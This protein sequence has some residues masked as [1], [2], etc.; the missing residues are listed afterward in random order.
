MIL[1]RSGASTNRLLARLS[2]L[3]DSSYV[4]YL[5]HILIITVTIAVLDLLDRTGDRLALT[6][7]VTVVAIGLAH[8]THRVIERPL[9]KA[10]HRRFA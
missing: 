1:E 9:T 10:L 2:V 6:L 7:L 3:G 4:L 8:L 5:C